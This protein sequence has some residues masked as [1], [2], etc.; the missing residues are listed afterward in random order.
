MY[1][2]S[3][4]THYRRVNKF[5]MNTCITFIPVCQAHGTTDLQSEGLSINFTFE[6]FF[7]NLPRK[8]R[9]HKNLTRITVLDTK[10]YVHLCQ[11]L[12]EFSLEKEVF[13]T[14]VK[15]EKNTFAISTSI[16]HFMRYGATYIVEPDKPHTA[17]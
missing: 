2:S 17:T 10:T 15:G 14:K 13:P 4:S 7:E 12:A 5:D 6:Y 16:V 1:N 9:F 11:K 3:T 8:F